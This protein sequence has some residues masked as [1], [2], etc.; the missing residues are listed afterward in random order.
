M[1]VKNIT[2]MGQIVFLVVFFIFTSVVVADAIERGC[3][4]V[5]I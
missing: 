4:V 5:N 1:Q 3:P 2:F